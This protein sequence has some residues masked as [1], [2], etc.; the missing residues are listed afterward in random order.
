[1]PVPVT[2]EIKV[3]FVSYHV[4]D[5]K[6]DDLMIL[7]TLG[8]YEGETVQKLIDDGWSFVSATR[9]F[10]L[11][12]PIN[13]TLPGYSPEVTRRDRIKCEHLNSKP[14]TGKFCHDCNQFFDLKVKE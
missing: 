12:D 1:M 8:G 10:E 2:D 14:A 7:D 5:G 13:I 4:K 9:K 3:G 6:I 11:G